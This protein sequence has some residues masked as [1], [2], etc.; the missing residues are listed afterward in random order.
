[1]LLLVIR[2]RRLVSTYIQRD[3]QSIVNVLWQ[4]IVCWQTWVGSICLVDKP[5]LADVA[6]AAGVHRATASR[7]LNPALV[8]RIS[9]VTT[10]KVQEA[11]ERLGYVPD[12]LGQGLRTNKTRTI[13]VLIPDLANPVFAPIVRGIE[14]HLR[15][16]GYEALLASTDNDP[17]REAT[18]L[19]VLQTRRCDGFIVAS[20]LRND[21]VVRHLLD[22]G[23]N[24]VLV[25]RLVDGLD[26]P[27]VVS[28]DAIGITAAIQHLFDL[29]H[30]VIGHIGGPLDVSVTTTRLGAYEKALASLGIDAPDAVEHAT[31]YT[32]EAG[33]A[34]FTRLLQRRPV[35]AVIAGN[36]LLA[37]GCYV[38]LAEYGLRCP[39][40][41][42][43]VGFNDMP[44]TAHLFPPL[45]TVTMPQHEMGCAAARMLL[46]R[47]NDPDL[48]P[49]MMAMP[50]AFVARESSGPTKRRTDGNTTD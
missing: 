6:K 33:R 27:A 39:D 15:E 40:D 28:D 42:S 2:Q 46:A 34:A 23:V 3:W 47:I 5:T 12:L 48:A 17:H 26:A 9:A 14:D 30:R 21:L 36:D 1:L 22:Q 45:S 8:G 18:L 44:L 13:G 29:G 38:A 49:T 24:V 50:T 37:V 25:N 41:V 16:H 7:A 32:V 35:S 4:S 11:A 31:G 20:A 10:A 43:V 19:D